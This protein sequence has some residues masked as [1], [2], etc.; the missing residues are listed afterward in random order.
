VTG[1]DGSYIFADLSSGT[2]TVRASATNLVLQ[3]PAHVSL[4]AGAQTLNLLL[5][6]AG[7]KQ[8]V[9]VTDTGPSTVS[10]EAGNN[11]SALVLTGTDLDALSDN[12][13]GAAVRRQ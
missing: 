9:T 3:Q 10:T 13:D 12:P 8:E 4:N 7:Q 1:N 11:A 5:N 6:V 2:Y